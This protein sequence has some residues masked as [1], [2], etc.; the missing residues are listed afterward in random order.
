MPH[1]VINDVEDE[2]ACH[3]VMTGS[4]KAASHYRAHCRAGTVRA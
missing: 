2:T 3:G 1:E 4:I